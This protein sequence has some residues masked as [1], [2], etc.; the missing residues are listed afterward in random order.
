MGF[1]SPP[2]P[3]PAR[4]QRNLFYGLVIVNTEIKI[5]ML[6]FFCCPF[7]GFS[8]VYW[9]LFIKILSRLFFF[10]LLS[11]FQHRIS[12]CLSAQDLE[13]GQVGLT[14]PFPHTVWVSG[15]VPLVIGLAWRSLPGRTEMW[16]SQAGFMEM[17][18]PLVLPSTEWIH[19]H[20]DAS[21]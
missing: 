10:S 19:R 16:T 13:G 1:L 20:P 5:S 11:F 18:R 9:P 8:S 3:H 17:S 14:Q 2:T 15:P 4:L 6:N 7:W 21:T 12:M